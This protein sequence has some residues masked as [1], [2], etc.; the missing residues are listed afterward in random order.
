M[1]DNYDQQDVTEISLL[2]ATTLKTADL[3]CDH[4]N[5]IGNV[6]VE[7]KWPTYQN[8][9]SSLIV[10]KEPQYMRWLTLCPQA[11]YFILKEY[12]YL[13]CPKCGKTR[14][15]IASNSTYHPG[16]IR[17]SLNCHDKH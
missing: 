9:N 16:W 4:C 2:P 13:C 3:Y 17:S 10:S 14:L 6:L 12:E 1:I 7:A 15:H 5:Y 11:I 8:P